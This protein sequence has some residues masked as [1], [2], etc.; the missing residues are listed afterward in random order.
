[1]SSG[2]VSKICAAAIAAFLSGPGAAHAY[3][4]T[5]QMMEWC[6]PVVHA[7]PL[8]DGN[9]QSVHTH[10]SGLCWGAFLA[11]DALSSLHEMNDP[12]TSIIGICPPK[13]MDSTAQATVQMVRIFDAYARQHP[14][15][16]HDSFVVIAL[17]AL[18]S[19]FP[20]K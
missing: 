7:T 8:P 19:V 1:M 18:H 17:P 16:Q 10:E 9:T 11:L 15:I 14:E 12:K 20:C 2:Q 13:V 4:S 6:K 3:I 5:M